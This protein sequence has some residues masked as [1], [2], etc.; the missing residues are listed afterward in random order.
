MIEGDL[1]FQ[2]NWKDLNSKDLEASKEL[3]NKQEK[4]RARL[5]RVFVGDELLPSYSWEC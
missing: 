3:R 1:C 2:I 5:F 4:T